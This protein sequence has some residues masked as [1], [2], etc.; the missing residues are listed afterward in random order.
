[1]CVY[2]YACVCGVWCVWVYI[3][4]ICVCVCLSK[5]IVWAGVIVPIFSPS[6]WKLRQDNHK[7][8]ASVSY[9]GRSPIKG[10]KGNAMS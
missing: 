4:V 9:I 5:T 6:T 8:K 3:C 10:G 7:F 2:M 1:M